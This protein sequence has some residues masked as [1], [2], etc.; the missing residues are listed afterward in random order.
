MINQ[1]LVI[2][3]ETGISGLDAIKFSG[4]LID[5][6]SVLYPDR[7]DEFSLTTPDLRVSDLLPVAGDRQ[8]FPLPA[9]PMIWSNSGLGSKVERVETR[10]K[11]KA[12]LKFVDLETLKKIVSRFEEAGYS[13]IYTQDILDKAGDDIGEI[14]SLKS[15]AV[16]GVMIDPVTSESTVYT[17]EMMRLDQSLK[18]WIFIASKNDEFLSAVAYLQDSGVSTRRSTG[19]GKIKARGARFPA[20]FGFTGEGLYLFLSPFI[21][22]SDDLNNIEFTKSAYDISVFA[23]TNST[24]SSTGIYRYF[25]TGSVLYLKEAVKGKWIRPNKKRLLNFSGT[26]VRV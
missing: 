26:Y 25:Q 16:P 5:A 22:S 18:Q 24:G 6:F 13:A 3:G 2:S 9:V 4:A 23:G 1:Y 15:A 19:W 14:A 20:K 12:L 21:P 17:K 10:R 11:K 8:L 7:M